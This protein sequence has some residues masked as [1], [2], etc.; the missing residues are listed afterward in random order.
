MDLTWLVV[1][2]YIAVPLSLVWLCACTQSCISA[3]CV[4]KMLCGELLSFMTFFLFC[5]MLVKRAVL[6]VYVYD[7][8]STSTNSVIEYRRRRRVGCRL[9][10]EMILRAVGFP[11]TNREPDQALSFTHH[12]CPT[13][14]V[15][16]YICFHRY[17]SNL[18]ISCTVLVCYN[19]SSALRFTVTHIAAV[20]FLRTNVL[21]T[22]SCMLSMLQ[23]HYC[24]VQRLCCA[25]RCN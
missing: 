20:C 4:W 9:S 22:I 1:Y 18:S 17:S 5:G 10:G 2:L 24:H 13:N 19:L 3:C 8:A 12:R 15:L 11:L 6:F 25:W 16:V 23:S 7:A 21:T 14:V